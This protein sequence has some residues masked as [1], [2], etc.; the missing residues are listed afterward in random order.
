MDKSWIIWLAFKINSKIFRTS[1]KLS[2]HLIFLIKLFNTNNKN[3]MLDCE[4]QANKNISGNQ[5]IIVKE[6][7]FFKFISISINKTIDYK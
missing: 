3:Q 7:D 4:Q 1:Q 5:N 2:K 6:I